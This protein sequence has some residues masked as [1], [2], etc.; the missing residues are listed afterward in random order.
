MAEREC[1][2][3]IRRP[4]GSELRCR[5]LEARGSKWAYCGKQYFCRVTNRWEASGDAAACAIARK[6]EKDGETD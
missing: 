5:L 6:R 3:M 4:G 2:H 1:E